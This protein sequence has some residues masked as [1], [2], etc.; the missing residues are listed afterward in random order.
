ME[1]HDFEKLV[2]TQLDTAVEELRARQS[3]PKLKAYVDALLTHGLPEPIK[4]RLA[5]V[6]FRHIATPNYEVMRFLNAADSLTDYKPL[7]LEYTKDKFNNRNEWKFSLAKLRFHKGMNKAGEPIIEYKNIIDIND[8]NNKPLREV[9]TVFGTSLVDFHHGLLQK[10]FPHF[11][12]AAYDLSEWLHAYG[13]T[14]R[15]YYKYFLAIFLQNGILFENFLVDGKEAGFTEEIILPALA[16][17]RAESGYKPLI[18]PLE[19]TT[20]EGDAFWL[21]HPYDR[22]KDIDTLS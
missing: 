20:I 3:D 11:T 2:Y 21:S 9:T 15:E 12:D 7:V 19:P 6:L 18:V 14:A 10:H 5:I 17:L 8:A 13:H 16:E 4:D 22:K 1:R